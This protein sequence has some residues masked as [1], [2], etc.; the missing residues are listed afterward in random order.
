MVGQTIGKYRI[1]E[2]I[3]R[4]GM[5]TV[6]KAIDE[7]LNRR[8]ALKLLNADLIDPDAVER[9]RR[10]ALM[11]AKLNH[12]RI[13]AIHEL[14]RDGHD[15]LMVMEFLEGET[16]EKLIER[17]PMTVPRAVALCSQV[18]EALEYAHGAGVIHRD[19]KPANLMLSPSGDIKVMDFGIAR[20]QGSEHL[21]TNGYMV[22]TPAYMAPEQVRG[23]EVDP[24]MDLYSVAVV[25]YRMLTHHLPFHGDTAIAMIHS[26]L[27]NPPTPPQQFRADLPGWIVG[28]LDRGLA[29]KPGDRFQSAREFRVALEKGLTGK[30]PSLKPTTAPTSS[31]MPAPP[32]T[33]NMPAPPATRNIP[34]PSPSGTFPG[35]ATASLSPS[36]V[37]PSSGTASAAMPS[38]AIPRVDA[39]P[40]PPAPPPAGSTTVT[41]RT[42]HLATIGGLV[43][44]LV[45]GGGALAFV[46][47]R[48]PATTVIVPASSTSQTDSGPDTAQQPPVPAPVGL[49]ATPP[50]PAT[51]QAAA[52]PAPTPAPRVQEAP[53]TPTAPALAANPQAATAAPSA[54]ATPNGAAPS[55]NAA[56]TAAA[57][58]PDMPALPAA[59]SAPAQDFGEVKAVVFEGSKS[60]EVDAQLSLEPGNLVVRGKS[61]NVLRTVPYSSIAA[62]TYARARRPRGQ[63]VA[64]AS[65]VPDDVISSGLFSGARH[66]LTL[67]LPNDY[68]IIRLE[69][70]NVIPV[71]NGLEAR[72][73]TRIPRTQSN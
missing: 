69:D 65:N 71:L 38:A 15:L 8:V 26:Q 41:L 22:G 25:L 68:V 58:A 44:A 27:N 4:G 12:G 45:I 28:I 40:Q 63:T 56:A 10:E 42:G 2:Q 60:R 20:V 18:L 16:F 50:E 33:R 6:Y 5:G 24:R 55:G 23:E 13:G 48:Q 70:R 14:T 66:W 3:G 37:T 34:A 35:S 36:S 47:L 31:G 73:G 59:A 39:V 32:A 54:A 57:A 43:L 19:L 46:A 67:Q 21:T 7:T 1:V 30:A 29:K 53:R 52:A 11:L 72:T 51:P 49:S 61:G 9:F 64:G 62:A 17:G